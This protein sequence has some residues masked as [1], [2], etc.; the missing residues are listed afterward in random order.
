MLWAKQTARL[1][2]C[3]LRAHYVLDTDDTEVTT[4]PPSK[5]P[6]STGKIHKKATVIQS[7][8]CHY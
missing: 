1:M 6:Q 3:L 8:K 4:V 7:G 5:K 2:K